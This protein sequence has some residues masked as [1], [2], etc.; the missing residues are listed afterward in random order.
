MGKEHDIQKFEGEPEM[1]NPE[2]RATMST[3]RKQ[4]KRKQNKK[5]MCTTNL[6]K[7]MHFVMMIVVFVVM[8]ST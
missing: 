2:T 8:T 4:N 1:D 7:A 5:E 3:K 6:I